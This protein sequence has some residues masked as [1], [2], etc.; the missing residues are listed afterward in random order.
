MKGQL[1]ISNVYV[2]G[3]DQQRSFLWDAGCQKEKSVIYEE[4]LEKV[5]QDAADDVRDVRVTAG[6]D[7][8]AACSSSTEWREIFIG[9]S[10]VH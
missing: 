8:W 10:V 6:Q 9:I 5:S 7:N 3:G 4:T 2:Q 1:F